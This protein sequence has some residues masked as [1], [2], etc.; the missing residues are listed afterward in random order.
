MRPWLPLASSLT[1]TANLAIWHSQQASHNRGATWLK[2]LRQWWP[3]S[4]RDLTLP[5]DGV[6]VR[7]VRP[8]R[9]T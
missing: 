3:R 6:A 1:V 2:D 8:S 5:I 9:T 7:H 4:G